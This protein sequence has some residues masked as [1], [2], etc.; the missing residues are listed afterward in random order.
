MKPKF[1]DSIVLFMIAPLTMVTIVLLILTFSST[2]KT[3]GKTLDHK[4][5][6]MI[7]KDKDTILD[8]YDIDAEYLNFKIHEMKI[9]EKKNNDLIK[10]REGNDEIKMDS[11]ETTLPTTNNLKIENMQ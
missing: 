2:T 7:K 11:E 5:V 10:I 4:D 9:I 1:L 6:S 8:P 3:I